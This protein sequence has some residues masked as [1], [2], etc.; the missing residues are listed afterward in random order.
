MKIV[1]FAVEDLTCP[2]CIKKIEGALSKKSGVDEAKVLFNSSK[3]KVVFEEDAVVFDKTGTLTKGKPEVT[4]IA[5][6]GMSE[7]EL[8]KIVAEAERISEHH[9]G[10]TIV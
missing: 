2:S 7:N 9:L 1:K 10:R 5:A 6:F 3:V 4:A 8:L